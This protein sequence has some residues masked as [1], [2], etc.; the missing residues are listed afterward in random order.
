MKRFWFL[1]LAMIMTFSFIGCSSNEAAK[2][3]PEDKSDSKVEAP[4]KEENKQEVK[5]EDKGKV[6]VYS[7]GPKGLS[8]AIQ[9]KF[10]AKTGIKMELVQSTTGKILG[11]LEAEKTNPIADVAVLASWPSAMGL[12]TEGMTQAY[13]EA[14]NADKLNEGWKDEDNHIFGY[15][16]SALGITY[17]TELV[18]KPGED[19]IDYTKSEWK[20]KV[21]IPDPSLSGSCMD[22]VSGYLYS[23]PDNGWDLFEGLKANEVSVA[24]ANKVALEPVITGAKSVVLA[25]VDYMAYSNKAKGEPVDIVYPKSGTVVNPRAVV[26]LR[27]AKNVENAQALV[28]FMLTEEAQ[29]LVMDAYILP[30]RKDLKCTNRANLD[31]IPLL[32]YDWNTM[33]ENQEEN[34]TKFIE[35]FK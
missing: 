1:L 24:G 21:N 16:G 15:S 7:A 31:E 28:D 3:T 35:I 34:I 6:V 11:K 14:K 22:F 30:G 2:M 5:D 9:E 23:Y 13:P 25:G 32:T 27:D 8:S 20:G 10:E 18:T 4:A 29:R 26:I 19:W 33:M 12:K 17:N